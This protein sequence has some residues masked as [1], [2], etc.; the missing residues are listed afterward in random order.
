[1][2]GLQVIDRSRRTASLGAAAGPSALVG[3]HEQAGVRPVPRN[4]RYGLYH[5]AVLLPD[6]ASLGRFARHVSGLG[7]PAGTADHLPRREDV[8]A[9]ARHVSSAGFPADADGASR[10]AMDPW[11]THVRITSAAVD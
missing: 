3:L 7:I 5:F 9:V 11:G 1:V 4:G 8:E 6:R 2:L 10:V